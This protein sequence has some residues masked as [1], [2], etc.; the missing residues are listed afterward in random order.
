MAESNQVACLSHSA[1]SPWANMMD[2]QFYIGVVV[3]APSTY[4]IS[5]PIALDDGHAK[6][7]ALVP[8]QLIRNK[9]EPMGKK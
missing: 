2:V 4:S 1:D 5:K 6:P 7:S 3:R 8:Y 9:H